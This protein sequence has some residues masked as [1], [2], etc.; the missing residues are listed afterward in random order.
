M[1]AYYTYERKLIYY[2]FR[3]VFPYIQLEPTRPEDARHFIDIY[4]N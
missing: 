3:H 2:D 1:N 4:R